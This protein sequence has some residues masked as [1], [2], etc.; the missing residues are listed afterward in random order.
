MLP[1]QSLFSGTDIY[2]PQEF[3]N[4]GNYTP[5]AGTVWSIGCLAFIL[6][7]R[8]PPFV[9]R[10]HVKTH[11]SIT[12]LNPDDGGL[13][14]LVEMCLVKDPAKRWRLEDLASFPLLQELE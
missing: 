2:I 3:Y 7:N 13:K 9:N 11:E 6:L 12:W 4:E 8:R 14:E 1:N 10:E 5:D